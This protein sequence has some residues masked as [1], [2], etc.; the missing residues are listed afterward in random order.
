MHKRKC[1]TCRFYQDASLA[2]SGWC[3]HPQ[4]RGATA[5]VMVRSNE[6]GCRTAW[7]DDL[8][9][10]MPDG[11]AAAEGAIDGAE[12]FAAQRVAPATANEIDALIAG[13][14]AGDGS[15]GAAAVDVVVATSLML[16]EGP[17]PGVDDGLRHSRWDD[18]ADVAPLSGDP[19]A[20]PRSAIIRAKDRYRADNVVTRPMAGALG[21]DVENA[22]GPSFAEPLLPLFEWTAVEPGEQRRETARGDDPSFPGAVPPAER[23]SA[24]AFVDD[25]R[26]DVVPSIDPGFELPRARRFGDPPRFPES[27]VEAA[28]ATPIVEPVHA[29]VLVAPAEAIDGMD[30]PMADEESARGDDATV[31]TPPAARSKRASLWPWGRLG[32]RERSAS[33]AF[34]AFDGVDDD[35]SLA[36]EESAAHP[37]ESFVVADEAPVHRPV[38]EQAVMVHESPLPPVHGRRHNNTVDDGGSEMNAGADRDPAVIRR[39][40]DLYPSLAPPAS[41]RSVGSWSDV[42]PVPV[43]EVANRDML[44][45][46]RAVFVA[47]ELRVSPKP[48]VESPLGPEQSGPIGPIDADHLA[49]DRDDVPAAVAAQAGDRWSSTGGANLHDAEFVEVEVVADRSDGAA[50]REGGAD[51]DTVIPD[52]I[53]IAETFDLTLDVEIDLFPDVPRMCQTCRDFRPAEGGERG[54][55]TNRQAFIHRRMVELD[56]LPCETSIGAWWLPADRVWL[57]AINA[58]AADAPTPALD[59][60]LPDFGVEE[61]PVRRQRRR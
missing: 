19:T 46:T 13:Q 33:D 38:V 36:D 17:T 50:C 44:D 26:Y 7:A 31:E 18:E 11:G 27:M 2:R 34:G 59:K 56:E 37:S 40:V 39:R 53:V 52:P 10:P 14:R 43:A 5:M 22:V 29:V 25:A 54:W 9:N 8:W 20:N 28:I 32:Q 21:H 3:L 47:P 55:C 57:P 24:P 51:R 41:T 48:R 23:V 60:Y 16:S 1:G 49:W 35:W 58:D 6:I 30:D 12:R 15:P 4:R 45:V 42:G 61:E